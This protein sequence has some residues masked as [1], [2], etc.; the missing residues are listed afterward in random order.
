MGQNIIANYV[1]VYIIVKTRCQRGTIDDIGFATCME[2][3]LRRG[4][5]GCGVNNLLLPNKKSN[6]CI[7]AT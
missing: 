7:W 6:Y 5:G 3:C 1:S 4:N 2:T